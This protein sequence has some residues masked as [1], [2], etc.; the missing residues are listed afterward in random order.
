MTDAILD[1]FVTLF[2]GRADCYGS[3]AGGCVRQQLTPRLFWQHLTA[4]PHIG[5]YPAFNID[6]VAHCVWGCV[7]IDY[8]SSEE[9][10]LIQSTLAA[11]KVDAWTERTRKGWH[12]WVFADELVPAEHMRNM[13]LAAHQVCGLVPK[14]VNPKQTVL[15]HGHVGNYVRLPYP[16]GDSALERYVVH[17]GRPDLRLTLEEFVPAALAARTPVAQITDLAGYY[18]PPAAPVYTVAAPSHDITSA[19]N[20]LSGLGRTI[21]RHGPLEGRDRSS[22][23]TK[24]AHEC[25]RSGVPPEDA[26]LLLEDADLR[27]GKYL[28][29][30]PQG[31][32]ELIK[33]VHRA[34]GSVPVSDLTPS[35]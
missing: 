14:E 3:W 31:E 34:Y 4:G 33:L 21:W 27:W 32:M 7:D 22:T 15:P 2:R 10:H 35:S 20:Q 5:V 9:A 17:A 8:D 11:V 6:G 1:G 12:I 13:L 23:M 19:A 26:L 28:A 16:S 30:G 25:H 29:R 24:L 18:Q